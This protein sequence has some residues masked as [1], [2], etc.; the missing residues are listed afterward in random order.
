MEIRYAREDRVP[1]S[2]GRHSRFFRLF[3]LI[4]VISVLYLSTRTWLGI[5]LSS[6]ELARRAE[7]LSQCKY[8]KTPAGPP[9]NFHARSESDRFSPDAK[10][11]VIKNA[12]IWTSGHNGTE[13]IQGDLLLLKG[14]IRE[15]GSI[16][17]SLVSGLDIEVVDVNGAWVT[18]GIVDLHSHLG[19]VKKLGLK[20][21]SCCLHA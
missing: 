4:V 1:I 11:T 20:G 19:V 21:K 2:S 7:A 3:T 18:P 14:L 8:I 15:V 9:A 17:P 16:T 12:T 6:A 5:R 10:P 13:I